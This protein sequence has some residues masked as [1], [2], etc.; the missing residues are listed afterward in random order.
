M[1]SNKKWVTVGRKVQKCQTQ[2][3]YSPTIDEKAP[4]IV[5]TFGLSEYNLRLKSL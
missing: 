4:T 5:V 1:L 2:S 3:T